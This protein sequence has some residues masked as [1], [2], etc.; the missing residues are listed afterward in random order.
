MKSAS[1]NDR[2]AGVPGL[3]DRLEFLVGSLAFCVSIVVSILKVSNVP[4]LVVTLSFAVTFDVP[5]RFQLTPAEVLTS[6]DL[7]DQ[8]LPTASGSLTPV[9]SLGVNRHVPLFVTFQ[10]RSKD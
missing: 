4:A 7:K 8:L 6:V 3:L 9:P 5:E 2:S 1:P 10:E